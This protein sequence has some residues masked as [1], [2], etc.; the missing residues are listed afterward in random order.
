VPDR[1]AF[2]LHVARAAGVA[3]PVTALLEGR[4]SALPLGE[5]TD[6]AVLDAALTLEHHAIALYQHALDRSMVPLALRRYAVEF[7]GDHH[8][9]RDT[10]V[11][12]VEERG[13]QAPRPLA[14]YDFGGFQAGDETVQQLLDIE[15][16]AQKAY[17]TLLSRVSG[18]DTLL[19]AAFILIDEV[20]HMTVWQRVLGLKIY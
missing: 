6:M 18:D 11:A 20:R 12:M 17:T 19:S 10:Q 16:A 2:V 14:H 13:R 9:H 4:A 5:G 3:L 15:I 1:R 8:G 7:I